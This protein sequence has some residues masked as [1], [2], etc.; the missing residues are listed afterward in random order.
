MHF[1]AVTLLNSKYAIPVLMLALLAIT[2]VLYQPGLF[3]NFIFDDYVNI[4]TNGQVHMTSLSWPDLATT[5]S[6]GLSSTLSRPLSMLSFGL[7]HYFSGLDPLA[8]KL[9]NLCI[10]LAASV[11]IY[12]LSRELLYIGL[13]PEAA[14]R[15][16]LQ[17]LALF[18]TACWALHPLNVSTVLYIVQ[19][20]TLLSSLIVIFTLVLYCKFRQDDTASKRQ[21]LITFGSICLLLVTGILFKETA[22]LL[23]LFILALEIFLLHFQAASAAQRLFLRL[24]VVFLLIVPAILVLVLLELAPEEVI[25]NYTIRSF[26]MWERLLTEAR[27]LWEYIHWLIMPDTR[28]FT[29]YHDNFPVSHSL[30]APITTLFAVVGL[31]GLI[32][33]VWLYRKK[34]PMLGFGIAFFL[35]GH[36]LES[37]F[38]ALELVFEH[39]NYLPGFGLLFGG[40]YT[41]LN[42]PHFIMRKPVAV[43]FLA[44]FLIFLTH[45]TFQ[46]SRK[47][48]NVHDQLISS[49][50]QSPDS[51]RINYS[52]GFLY[53][54]VAS[55]T[56]D[57][58]ETLEA[59]SRYFLRASELDSRAT[60][61]HVG[62]ILATSQLGKPIDAALMDDLAFRLQNYPL[63]ENVL[64]EISML[65]EC[66]Y[67]GFCKFEKESLIRL[68]NAIA[69]NDASDAVVIQAIL[70]QLGTAITNVF[71]SKD[72]GKALLYLAESIR[73]ELTVIDVKLVQIE[74]DQGNYLQARSV[75]QAA[76]AKSANASLMEDLL[77]LS[78]E[79]D[80]R[81]NAE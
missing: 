24:Y 57:M 23:V 40:I 27:A 62:Y 26:S 45:G 60:R 44:I 20:M 5:L 8:F 48:A 59:A 6:S 32:T 71:K 70:D 13:K 25:G 30:L 54:S 78:R 64:T 46:E 31:A 3:G 77:R 19:R 12:M 47:W 34:L 72:D 18:I 10:H 15:R 43:A 35:A 50:R 75:L 41:L 33:F 53:L 67:G 7:N 38:V 1:K 63:A 37:T 79:L 51:H 61:G 52:L 21:A 81:E 39:R 76:L 65:S 17:L 16:K 68:Y 42:L 74:M 9:T 56:P 58:Q 66:W 28:E 2:F 4:V 36:A 69:N 11:G 49:V 29:L 73:E 55:Q 80:Q 22:A 14:D